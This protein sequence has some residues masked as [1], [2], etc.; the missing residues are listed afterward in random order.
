MR[1]HHLLDRGRHLLGAGCGP[2]PGGPVLPHQQPTP[3]TRTLLPIAILLSSFAHAQL[4]TVPADR[5]QL[6]RMQASGTAA[7][8][9]DKVRYERV[10]VALRPS[11]TGD[12]LRVV[13]PTND[14]YAVRI[15]GPTGSL[16]MT[17]TYRDAGL[18][19][20]HGAFAF[21]HPN[22]RLESSGTYV[23]GRKHGV[24]LRYN[25]VGRALAERCYGVTEPE[26][27]LE[28]HGWASRAAV[29]DGVSAEK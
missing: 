29:V 16:R 12:H 17:G 23:D 24:W 13:S 1:P 15:T 22:G 7:L 10:D 21:H 27:V 25:A 19:V 3:M 18:Q 28:A 26:A 9:V 20:A 5:E 6:S 8:T 4:S 2:W 14:G 11:P